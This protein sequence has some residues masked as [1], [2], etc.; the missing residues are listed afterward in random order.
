MTPMFTVTA[1]E[2]VSGDLVWQQTTPTNSAI[3]ASG[4]LVTAGDLVLQGTDLGE[5]YAF[6]AGTGDQLFLYQH[7]RPIRASPMTYQVNGK[8]YISVVS[9]NTLLTFALPLPG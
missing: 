5:L 9:T 4:N 1:Y 6:D 2:P 8:Q 3:G 7:D